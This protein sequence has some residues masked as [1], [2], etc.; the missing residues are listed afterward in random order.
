M[1]RKERPSRSGDEFVASWSRRC[2]ASAAGCRCR[3][4]TIAMLTSC[5]PRRDAGNQCAAQRFMFCNVGK[6][7]FEAVA[8]TDF[9]VNVPP[10][11]A[12][13][14]LARSETFCLSARRCV[15]GRPTHKYV[16]VLP[17]P[18]STRFP[19]RLR[20]VVAGGLMLP[21]FSD[22]PALSTTCVLPLYL[23]GAPNRS[24][25]T[26][27]RPRAGFGCVPFLRNNFRRGHSA[28]RERDGG[29][30]RDCL[31]PDP[32]LLSCPLRV[33]SCRCN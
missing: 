12:T 27:A 7:P 21:A 26:G 24:G 32:T 33:E 15:G 1:G 6:C 28:A 29:A 17:A 22:P 31:N 2:A 11:T 18:W 3:S 13:V 30:C 9:I 8:V 19:L 14:P 10:P 20:V 16:E 23:S 4:W 5:S 25:L